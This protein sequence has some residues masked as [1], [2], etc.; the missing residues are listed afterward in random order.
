[1]HANFVWEDLYADVWKP[2]CRNNCLYCSLTI[3]TSNVLVT[4]MSIYTMYSPTGYVQES[5]RRWD[6]W[7]MFKTPVHAIDTIGSVMSK[8][9]WLDCF[10]TGLLIL[11]STCTLEYIYTCSLAQ[12]FMTHGNGGRYRYHIW[13]SVFGD[14]LR[15]L[16]C[17]YI[18]IIKEMSMFGFSTRNK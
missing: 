2:T 8:W 7:R 16:G 3:W 15:I 6:R 11:A 14:T 10:P 17:L 13:T 5:L 9:I 18:Y 1:M 12:V 4:F